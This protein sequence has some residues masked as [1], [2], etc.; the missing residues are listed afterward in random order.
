[1]KELQRIGK[2]ELQA[3]VENNN[4]I[5]MGCEFKDLLFKN[6]IVLNHIFNEMI[7]N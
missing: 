3:L 2:N 1:M 5:Q 7:R 4:I 6:M